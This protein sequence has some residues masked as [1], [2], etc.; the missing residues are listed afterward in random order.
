MGRYFLDEIADLEMGLQ[1]KIL[2]FLQDGCFARI[3][4]QAERAVNV[5][6]I[7]ATNKD[8]EQRNCRRKLSLRLVLQN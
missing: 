4:G 3:G 7:C 6:V 8:L 1:S 5:R 2:H